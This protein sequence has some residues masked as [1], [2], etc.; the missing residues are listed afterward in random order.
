MWNDILEP[1]KTCVN[2]VWIAYCCG[3]LPIG[4]AVH[5]ESGV[6]VSTGRN[7][8]NDSI[9]PD[10]YIHSNRQEEHSQAFG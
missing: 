5:H 9:Q 3:S 10:G 8:C 2:Q 4:A 6:L 1:L 7:Q